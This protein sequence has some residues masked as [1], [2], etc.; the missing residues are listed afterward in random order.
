MQVY[1][2][3]SFFFYTVPLVWRGYNSES[4]SPKLVYHYNPSS[5]VTL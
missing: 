5:H 3:F 2:I 1:E 4:E